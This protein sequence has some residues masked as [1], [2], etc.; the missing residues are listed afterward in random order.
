MTP[1]PVHGP[2]DLGNMNVSGYGSAGRHARELTAL[3]LHGTRLLE[4]TFGDRFTLLIA[5]S[6]KLPFSYLAPSKSVYAPQSLPAVV[7]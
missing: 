2:Q 5:L 7:V 6:L 1:D 3:R 4:A